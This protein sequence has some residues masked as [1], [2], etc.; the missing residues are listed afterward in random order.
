MFPPPGLDTGNADD[1][2]WDADKKDEVSNEAPGALDPR[3]K[4]A[5]SPGAED[6]ASRAYKSAGSL[7]GR[8]TGRRGCRAVT[9]GRDAGLS[10]RRR[11]LL[12]LQL[13][14]F[15][16][17]FWLAGHLLKRGVPPANSRA[18]PSSSDGDGPNRV[19]LISANVTSLDAHWAVCTEFAQHNASMICLQETRHSRKSV[20]PR[21]NLASVQRRMAC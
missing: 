5:E 20:K 3:A 13:P 18:D 6:S 14:L 11:C 19:H 10:R 9:S 17:G 2:D 8:G 1:V 15:P 7:S 12:F 16:G 21:T 4:A